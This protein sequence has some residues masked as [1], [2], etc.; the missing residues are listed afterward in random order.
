VFFGHVLLLADRALELEL[1]CF[2]SPIEANSFSKELRTL[3]SCSIVRRS[4]YVYIFG[5]QLLKAYIE[6]SYTHEAKS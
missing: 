3:F 2:D 6:I 5:L 1:I 4:F